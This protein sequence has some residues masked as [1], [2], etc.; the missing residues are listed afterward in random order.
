[1]THDFGIDLQI[2]VAVSSVNVACISSLGISVLNFLS[3]S[4]S[5]SELKYCVLVDFGN[6]FLKKIS[7]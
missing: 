3:F 5:Q 1:M 4:S 7:L 6:F 2:S